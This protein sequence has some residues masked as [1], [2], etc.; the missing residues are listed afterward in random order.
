MGAVDFLLVVLLTLAV[1]AAARHIVK[2]GGKC[3]CCDGCAGCRN[4]RKNGCEK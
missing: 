2:R 3:G 4:S 1:T